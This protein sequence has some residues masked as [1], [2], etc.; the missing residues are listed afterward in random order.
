MANI[1]VRQ[2]QGRMARER[3][4][5][6][7]AFL[8]PMR[9]IRELLGW[10]PFAQMLPTLREREG[11]MWVPEFDVKET[12]DALIFR[13]DMPGIEEKDLDI[14]LTGNRLTVSGKR[15]AE[16]EQKGETWY[17]CERSYGSFTRSFTL[18]EA[19]DTEH[20]RASLDKGVLTLTVPK[21]PQAQP[22]KIPLASQPKQQQKQ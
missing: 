16:E 19:A 7:V 2:D 10:D 13:A 8:D 21:K 14:T 11:G 6:R 15:E 3:E 22:K 9:Q 18:P 5:P 1:T 12:N 17:A 4:T 20:L